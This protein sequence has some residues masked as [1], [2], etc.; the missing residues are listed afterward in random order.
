MF[1]YRFFISQLSILN[2][3]SAAFRRFCS[4]LFCLV[5]FHS[6]PLRFALFH[7]VLLCCYVVMLSWFFLFCSVFCSALCSVLCSVLFCSV[8]FCSVLFC[9]VLF[10]SVLFC[11]VLLC[12]VLFS[13]AVPYCTVPSLPFRDNLPSLS[14]PFLAQKLDRKIK[15]R[16][17]KG[18][19]VAAPIRLSLSASGCKL[20][21]GFK[22]YILIQLIIRFNNVGSTLTGDD[23]HHGFEMFL[24][25]RQTW[26]PIWQEHI[27]ENDRGKT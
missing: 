4:V 26:L 23:F 14:L 21:N 7:Y 6:V 22:L 13:Q 8:L 12:S 25:G 24:P 3:T 9:S 5:P 15:N 18:F 16:K 10:C 1:L 19:F 17:N 27:V 11:F 20:F 2:F